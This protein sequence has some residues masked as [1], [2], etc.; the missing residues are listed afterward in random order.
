MALLYLITPVNYGPTIRAI[1]LPQPEVIPTGRS[2]A[3]GWGSTGPLGMKL[4]NIHRRKKT[5]DYKAVNF[6]K[7]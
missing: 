2:T 1:L 7:F 4:H 3:A 6:F 5:S